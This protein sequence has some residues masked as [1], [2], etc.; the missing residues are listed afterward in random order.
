MAPSAEDRHVRAKCRQY[1][2][3][4]REDGEDLANDS[5]YPDMGLQ[6]IEDRSRGGERF[7][8]VWCFF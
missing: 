5:M 4:E 6:E 2:S 3:D 1:Y 8:F 7:L